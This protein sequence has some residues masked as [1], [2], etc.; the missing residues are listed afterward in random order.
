MKI[1]II[2]LLVFLLYNTLICSTIEDVT[3][4]QPAI[5]KEITATESNLQILDKLH[6][7]YYDVMIFFGILV[8]FIGILLPLFINF[9]QT[10]KLKIEK[11]NLKQE[12][13]VEIKS[14]IKN[15]FDLYEE[16][17]KEKI[18]KMEIGFKEKIEKM[19]IGFEKKSDAM[20]GMVFHV[21]GRFELNK[22]YYAQSLVSYIY[23]SSFYLEGEDYGNFQRVTK[24][25]C[26][27]CFPMLFSSDFDIVNDLEKRVNNFIKL[28][29][30]YNNKARYTNLINALEKELLKA[31]KRERPTQT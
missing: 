1:I 28:L 2:V 29:T 30:K 9:Y 10:K 31:K 17:F 4:E 24:T 5:Q 12:L 23:A 6:S 13:L 27:S 11:E 8:A 19:E 25:I 21:Q 22:R 18:E 26:E 15:E 3:S 14:E 7:L 20:S 16:K